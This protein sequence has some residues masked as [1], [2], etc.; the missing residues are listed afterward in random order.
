MLSTV[1]LL[2][3]G[4]KSVGITRWVAWSCERM[5]RKDTGKFW[6][7]QIIARMYSCLHLLRFITHLYITSNCVPSL[8]LFF[9]SSSASTMSF[10]NIVSQPPKVLKI[11]FVMPLAPETMGETGWLQPDERRQSTCVHRLAG[12]EKTHLA[13]RRRRVWVAVL[14]PIQAS[15]RCPMPHVLLTWLALTPDCPN[16]D[17][18]ISRH[19]WV[20]RYCRQVIG[21]DP[22]IIPPFSTFFFWYVNSMF[23]RLEFMSDHENKERPKSSHKDSTFVRDFCQKKCLKSTF[24]SNLYQNVNN[25]S[26]WNKSRYIFSF[27]PLNWD[28]YLSI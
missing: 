5:E 8:L 25:P 27:F 23:N 6:R 22:Y 3:L 15:A 21:V 7:L 4:G 13:S 17:T 2:K 11:L 20:L 16:K 12:E 10:K 18:A 24:S 9:P 19:V 28:D 14:S 26:L 1:H